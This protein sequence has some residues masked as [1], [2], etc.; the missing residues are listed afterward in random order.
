MSLRLPELD[1]LAAQQS[2][3]GG[4]GSGVGQAIEKRHVEHLVFANAMASQNIAGAG[5][6]VKT[7]LRGSEQKIWRPEGA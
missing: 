6:N 5:Q 1:A 4:H 2:D 3:D 7:C